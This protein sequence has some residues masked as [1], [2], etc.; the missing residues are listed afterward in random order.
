MQILRPHPRNTESGTLGMSP[1]NLWFNKP[2][3]WFYC[4]LMFPNYRWENWDPEKGCNLCKPMDWLKQDHLIRIA[5]NYH[6]SRMMWGIWKRFRINL[7][8]GPRKKGKTLKWIVTLEPGEKDKERGCG[9]FHLWAGRA[10]EEWWAA[11]PHST[12][13]RNGGNS[14][15]EESRLNVRINFLTMRVVKC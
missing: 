12:E 10:K 1:S 3:G 8:T 13:S 7:Q 5:L 11:V 2:S 14:Q 4:T 6:S 9:S 15:Q